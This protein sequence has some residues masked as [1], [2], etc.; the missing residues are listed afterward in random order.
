[1][2]R[3]DEIGETNV[4]QSGLRHFRKPGVRGAMDQNCTAGILDG[5]QS[6]RA[7]FSHARNNDPDRSENTEP[8]RH[9]ET[10]GKGG[11]SAQYVVTTVSDVRNAAT[12]TS[13]Q[14]LNPLGSLVE[15]R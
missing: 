8:P 9:E 5:P 6:H 12:S 14:R 2:G 10:A 7:V 13:D 11:A 3:T 1:M 15:N 4:D